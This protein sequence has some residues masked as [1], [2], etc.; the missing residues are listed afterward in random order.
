MTGMSPTRGDASQRLSVSLFR[1][2]MHVQIARQSIR[3]H[4]V[5]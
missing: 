1:D 5:R 4:L 3:M 2:Q